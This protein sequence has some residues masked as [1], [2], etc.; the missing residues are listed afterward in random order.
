VG[1]CGDPWQGHRTVKR[2]RAG[3]RFVWSSTDKLAEL[4]A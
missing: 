3:R 2:R 4:V 1:N